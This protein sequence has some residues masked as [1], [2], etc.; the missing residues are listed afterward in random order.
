MVVIAVKLIYGNEPESNLTLFEL[1]L[2]RQS[3]ELSALL[4]GGFIAD[5]ES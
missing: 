3:L 5:K 4:K 1:A 2:F